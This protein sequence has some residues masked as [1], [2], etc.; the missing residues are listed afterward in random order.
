MIEPL[1]PF[2][3]S[4]C[5]MYMTKEEEGDWLHKKTKEM[6]NAGSSMWGY[7]KTCEDL[8]QFDGDKCMKCGKVQ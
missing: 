2:Y 8:T 3:A 7:C 6:M 4:I 5:C 1:P